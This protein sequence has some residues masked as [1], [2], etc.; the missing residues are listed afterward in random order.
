[1]GGKYA[2]E[3]WNYSR[4]LAGSIHGRRAKG[5]DL[6]PARRGLNDPAGGSSFAIASANRCGSSINDGVCP[7]WPH[8]STPG[9]V[10][11]AICLVDCGH[12]HFF[13]LGP[14]SMGAMVFEL[15][16][17]LSRNIFRP[18]TITV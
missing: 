5:S 16:S 13:M 14:H 17:C 10:H 12:S 1:M 4:R 18:R 15:V 3:F 11:S 7:A 9:M 2:C 6:Q 8:V